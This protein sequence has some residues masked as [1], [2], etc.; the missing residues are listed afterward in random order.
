[1]AFCSGVCCFHAY[2]ASDT[3]RLFMSLTFVVQGAGVEL[4][5]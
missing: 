1:L 3:W 2:R 4:V 5:P